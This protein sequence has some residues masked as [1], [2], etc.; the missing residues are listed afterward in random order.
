MHPQMFWMVW[1]SYCGLATLPT[2]VC[3]HI[4]LDGLNTACVHPRHTFG[5]EGKPRNPQELAQHQAVIY[6]RPDEDPCTEWQFV[7][8]DERVRVTLSVRLAVRD[9]NGL[10]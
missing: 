5:C 4:V 6:G 8:G 7:R 2:V 3:V 9:G 1:I 10:V